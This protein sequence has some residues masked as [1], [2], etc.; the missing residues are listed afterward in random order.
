[1]SVSKPNKNTTDQTITN[2]QNL[3]LQDLEGPT[4]AGRAGGDINMVT[5]DQGAVEAG[6]ALAAR[7]LDVSAQGNEDALEFGEGALTESLN[8][9]G[10][11]LEANVKTSDKALDFATLALQ[12]QDDQAEQ[13]LSTV[14]NT[15][16]TA[17]AQ[18]AQASRSDANDALKRVVK[19]AGIAIVALTIGAAVIGRTSS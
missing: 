14:A 10:D 12:S 18:V 1:M 15:G 5:T 6:T 13:A 8:F 3:N 4:V 19:V 11:A 2:T 16:Q 7:A 9:G 17:I